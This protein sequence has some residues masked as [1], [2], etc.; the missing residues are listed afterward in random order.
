VVVA[1]VGIAVRR[2][3]FVA[4]LLREGLALLVGHQP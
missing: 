2:P 3:A 4:Q 1:G